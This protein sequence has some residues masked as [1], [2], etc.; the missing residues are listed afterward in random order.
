M[1]NDFAETPSQFF[2]NWCYQTDFL[3]KISRHYIT[4]KSL[5]DNIIENI[6]N[7]ILCGF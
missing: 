5:P 4:K 1:E 2:E 3:K 6:K 7:G